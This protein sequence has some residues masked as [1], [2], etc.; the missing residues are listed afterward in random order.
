[1]TGSGALMARVSLVMMV[2]A[3]AI[4]I[5]GVVAVIEGSTRSI[6]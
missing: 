4:A 6:D 5:A 2:M 3:M 1:M